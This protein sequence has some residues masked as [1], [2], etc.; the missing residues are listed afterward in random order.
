MKKPILFAIIK[1]QVHIGNILSCDERNA[2]LS[3]LQSADLVKI[4]INHLKKY[5]V[6]K[7]MKDIHYL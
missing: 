4:D 1:N 3:Y 2:L 5:E 6:I 7:A